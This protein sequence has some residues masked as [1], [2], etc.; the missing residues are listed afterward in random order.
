MQKAPA[1]ALGIEKLNCLKR[2]EMKSN[3]AFGNKNNPHLFF[4]SFNLTTIHR[5]LDDYQF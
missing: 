5:L 4:N 1:Y 2:G 3:H